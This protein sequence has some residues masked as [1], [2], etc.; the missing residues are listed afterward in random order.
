MWVIQKRVVGIY[1]KSNWDQEGNIWG[2]EDAIISINR[3][4]INDVHT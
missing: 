2:E 1:Y 3:A 4:Q